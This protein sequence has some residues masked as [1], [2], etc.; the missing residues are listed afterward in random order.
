M[1]DVTENKLRL[2]ENYK[3]QLLFAGVQKKITATEFPER[4]E[5]MPFTLFPSIFPADVL[6]K[7]QGL[8]TAF[9]T[10]IYKVANDHEFMTKCLK[11]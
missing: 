10:V 8:Q 3:K 2:Y 9:Q 11:G 7:I 4:L 1:M 6:K 5:P